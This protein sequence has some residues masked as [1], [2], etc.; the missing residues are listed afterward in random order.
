MGLNLTFRSKDARS[1]PTGSTGK[2]ARLWDSSEK[3]R[4]SSVSPAL[5]K[6]NMSQNF[7]AHDRISPSRRMRL[8]RLSLQLISRRLDQ[9]PTDRFTRAVM[10]LRVKY[11]L[12]GG[13]DIRFGGQTRES[14]KTTPAGNA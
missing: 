5:A 9:N 4:F 3:P 8:L 6:S 11:K 7:P 12:P 10:R 13:T 2:I 1:S 14:A